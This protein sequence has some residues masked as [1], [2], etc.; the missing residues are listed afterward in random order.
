[1]DDS[2]NACDHSTEEERKSIWFALFFCV[3]LLKLE[4]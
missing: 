1:M 2:I 3:K 4:A